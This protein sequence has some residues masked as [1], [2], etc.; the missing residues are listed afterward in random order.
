[1]AHWHRDDCRHELSPQ[2]PDGRGFVLPGAKA[3]YLPEPVITT[4]HIELDVTPD[5]E[6]RTLSG[7]VKLS[8]ASAGLQVH[9][10]LSLDQRELE[11]HSVLAARPGGAAIA[12]R[13]RQTDRSL[14]VQLPG[15][16]ALGPQAPIELCID[17]HAAPRW[18]LFFVGPDGDHPKRPRQLWTLNQDDNARF[19]IP[20]L[21]HPSTRATMTLTARVPL[22]L[23]A[24][25]NG[26]L[27][28]QK[29][30]CGL[31]V[32]VWHMDRALP[33][34]LMTLMVGEFEVTE[35]GDRERQ[36]RYLAP[37]GRGVEAQ[38]NL[39]RTPEMIEL[40]SKWTG[41]PLP[42]ERYDQILV[43]DFL[44][45]GMEH[46]TAVTLTE[47]CLR[48][49]RAMLDSSCEPLTSHE[50]AHQWFGNTVTCREWPHG[51]LNEGF[52]T[53]C[54]NLWIEHSEG[55]EAARAAMLEVLDTYLNEARDSYSRPLVERRVHKNIDLFDA[56]LYDKGALVLNGL[57]GLL[58][59]DA[60]QAAV[61]HYLKR[62]GHSTVTS[63]DFERAIEEATGRR[64][65]SFFEQL[66]Y[67]AGHIELTAKAEW[68][69]QSGLVIIE[70]EQ[71]QDPSIRAAFELEL[72]VELASEQ[73]LIKQ[74]LS[75]SQRRQTFSIPCPAAPKYLSVDPQAWLPGPLTLEL[76]EEMLR[77][78]LVEGP[79]APERIRAAKA[80]GKKATRAAVEALEAAVETDRRWEVAAAAAAA[81]GS[82]GGVD[83]RE[84]LGRL[85]PRAKHPKTRRA[86][87]KAM[88]QLRDPAVADWLHTVLAGDA[89]I[90][91]EAEAARALAQARAADAQRALEGLL[92]HR[93]SWHET[94][95]VGAIDGLAELGDGPRSLP[96]ILP[97]LAAR[98][99]PDLRLAACRALVSLART[100]ER[101][102]RER[103][104]QEL[105]RALD[106]KS[107]RLRICIAEQ[108][109][110]LGDAASISALRRRLERDLDGRVER[111]CREAIASLEAQSPGDAR[112]RTLEAEL[113]KERSARA[114]LEN[115]VLELEKG[116]GQTKG[117]TQV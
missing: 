112:L 106:D 81:L 76:P 44:F 80:L 13:Y 10:S 91:V 43:H 37:P 84:A 7:R 92:E 53:W 90:F 109:A 82:I 99:D 17:Y 67:C 86:V 61:Q 20:C 47:R 45:G 117:E 28:E 105:E 57:R 79:C 15:G 98:E 58:G 77:A 101:G 78:L 114:S 52:A 35:S 60:F 108:L 49:E 29:Q 63:A 83:A 115:R 8:L 72:E 22:G 36:V 16:L 39:A 38:K 26:R 46:P 42:Y 116:R 96:L 97:R 103:V 56:H 3:S 94:V 66:V 73:G 110:R 65:D 89:S 27:L 31:E 21:D 2:R 14:E 68:R 59:P 48:D 23:S 4:R 62:Y 87:V 85:L 30:D 104:R 74:R 24:I 6:R 51:W 41:M 1:M 11:I 88:G 32:F 34:Y 55:V 12:C 75:L 5:F 33:P 19:W 93:D 71:T 100:S 54:E 64:V 111:A 9:E 113:Q 25:S 18:G 95:R 107:F 40:F 70:L 69:A 50:L 102:L